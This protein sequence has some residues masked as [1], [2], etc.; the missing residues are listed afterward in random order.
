MGKYLIGVVCVLMI[1]LALF[2]ALDAVISAKMQSREPY[3]TV[4]M[5]STR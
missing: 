2:F 4:R 1:D 3:Q 5:G